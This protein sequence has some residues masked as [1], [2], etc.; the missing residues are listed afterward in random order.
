MSKVDC[1][2]MI[3]DLPKNPERLAK[4]QRA[5]QLLAKARLDKPQ[6]PSSE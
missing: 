3:G 4:I 1:L 6:P 5:E 2:Y